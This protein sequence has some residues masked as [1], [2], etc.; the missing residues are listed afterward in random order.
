MPVWTARTAQPPEGLAEALTT[1]SATG[2]PVALLTEHWL[3]RD[4]GLR[5]GARL[6]LLTTHAGDDVPAVTAPGG[7]HVHL[8]PDADLLQLSQA[9]RLLLG[10]D[11]DPAG[12]SGGGP[13]RGGATARSRR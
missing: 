1:A 12:E 2:R 10:M 5:A 11:E 4:H 3:A 6:R 13:G 7:H 8:P 9:V